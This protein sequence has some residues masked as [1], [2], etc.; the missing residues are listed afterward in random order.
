MRR[1]NKIY[2]NKCGG[3]IRELSN[4][5]LRKI[6]QDRFK[7]TRTSYDIICKTCS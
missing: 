2:C 6:D 1:R 4:K 5:E 3:F 7:G